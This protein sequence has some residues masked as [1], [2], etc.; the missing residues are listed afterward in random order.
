MSS[1]YLTAEEAA[2]RLGVSRATLYAYVSR[3]R[4]RSRAVKGSR[5][6]QY[7]VADVQQLL[8]QKEGR[9]NP[10]RAAAKTLGFEGLPILESS[11]TLIDGGRFYYRGHDV[12]AL[13]ERGD[14]ERVIELLWGG[15]AHSA[16]LPVPARALQRQWSE[17]SFIPRAQ[18]YLAWR[19]N[20]D[21]TAQLL[22]SSHLPSIARQILLGLTQA[23]LL[24][25]EPIEDMPRVIA[26]SWG[27][28]TATRSLEAALIL[29]ADH[30]LNVSAFTARTIASAG[31]SPYMAISGALGA[32]SGSRHGGM[33]HLVGRLLD[34]P[35]AP[36]DVIRETLAISG[37]LPGFGHPLYPAGDPR[38][39]RLMASSK[40]GAEQRRSELFARHVYELSGLRPNLDF[41]LV[42]LARSWGLPGDAPVVLFALGRT[43]GWMAHAMEQYENGQLLRP[44]ARYVGPE[45]RTVT[46]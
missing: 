19:A 32:L 6:R 23:A 35:A 5:Q 21:P 29:S 14:L 37:D 22:A 45:A 40:A 8:M 41:G 42:T 12:L 38:G 31:A 11:V 24:H 43:I 28:P 39:Q 13:A 44:R 17:M 34:N 20:A 4:L 30:E 46:E 10:V 26:Q 7:S 33:T 15:P 36:H 25:F 9:Q 18:S 3:G 16:T 1:D 27:R 2:H